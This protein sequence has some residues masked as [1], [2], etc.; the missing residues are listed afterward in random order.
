MGPLLL[1]LSPLCL[2]MALLLLRLGLYKRVE[3]DFLERVAAG[4]FAG[5]VTMV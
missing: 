4:E 3:E 1:A 5:A 2:G